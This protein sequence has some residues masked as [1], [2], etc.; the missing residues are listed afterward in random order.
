MRI[1][2]ELRYKA[3]GGG[4]MLDSRQRIG[5]SE[6][7]RP[8]NTIHAAAPRFLGL[9]NTFAGAAALLLGEPP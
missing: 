8:H 7:A 2:W 1:K 9:T 4:K 5:D 3:G 6:I